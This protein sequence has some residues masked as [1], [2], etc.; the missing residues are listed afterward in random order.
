MYKKTV[1]I[2]VIVLLLATV[3][4]SR[5]SY[6]LGRLD[7]QGFAFQIDAQQL[8]IWLSLFCLSV[9]IVLFVGVLVRGSKAFL[10]TLLCGSALVCLSIYLNFCVGRHF[11]YQEISSNRRKACEIVAAIGVYRQKTGKFPTHLE[12]LGQSFDLMVSTGNE[13]DYIE[14]QGQQN[15]PTLFYRDGWYIYSYNWTTNGWEKSD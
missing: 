12:N 11:R 1:L 3:F 15:H 5:A 9:G 8:F 2:V 6:Q 4:F 10:F 14:Y 7:D 13:V